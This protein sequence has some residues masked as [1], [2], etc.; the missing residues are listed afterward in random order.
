M[1]RDAKVQ[2]SILGLR[3]IKLFAGLPDDVLETL[4]R[5]CGWRRFAPD[6]LVIAKEATD[7]DVYL[8]VGGKVRVRVLSPGGRLTAFRE[9]GAGEWIGD[10]AALDGLPRSADIVAIEDSLIATL[11]PDEFRTLMLKY[12][13]VAECVILRL[14]AL[15]RDLSDRVYDLSTLG[16]QNRV[17][18]EILRLAKVAGVAGNVARIDP[19]PKH[20]DIASQVSTYREQ[21]TRELSALTRRG[22]IQRDGSALVVSDVKWLEKLVEDVRNSN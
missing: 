6:Q 11:P 9:V 7:R 20:T 4:S 12:P 13:N 10:L 1:S 5:R 19:A 18:A 21:V 2:P 16:V 14:V 22:L 3:G 8:I 15:V 17:H